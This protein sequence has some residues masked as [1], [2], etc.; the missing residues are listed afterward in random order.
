MLAVSAEDV[1][2]FYADFY[3]FL[4]SAGIDSVKTD[5][6]F[7]LDE[8]DDAPDRAA[9]IRP[10]QNAW[11]LNCLRY[12]SAKAISCMSQAPQIIFH[13]QMPTNKP[14]IMLRNSDDFF[15][16]VPASHPWHV[17][18]N[19]YN[20]LFNQHLN[21]LPDWDMFQTSHPWASFHAAA[22]CVSGGPIYITDVPGAHDVNLIRQM[23]ANTPRGDTVILRPHTIGKTIS[24]YV[25]YDEPVLLKVATYVGRHG[26]GT[27][28]LGVFNTTTRPLTE[29]IPVGDFPGTVPENL[30]LVRAHSSGAIAGPFHPT[31]KLALVQAELPTQ[32]WDILTAYPVKE[33]ELQ[34]R[35]DGIKGDKTIRVSNL[36]LLG[37]MTGAAA[38]VNSDI[39]VDRNSGRLRCWTSLKALGVWGLYVSD[40]ENR[41]LE[42]DFIAVLFG[43]EIPRHC[44]RRSEVPNVLEIDVARAWK[45]SEQR[46]GWSNEVAIEVVIR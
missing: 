5:A 30:Y 16:E 20:T 17:Y 1:Q 15:P 27:P 41:S 9:L 21:V 7:F 25:G 11:I 39:Y 24:P 18:C 23:T 33:L 8:L 28:I 19:A 32:S 12:F 42:D 45:E 13:S 2:Q 38:I 43:R 26:T 4:N 10:Y 31:N 46:A 35:H 3:S 37:K 36:G 22:R 34:R 29:L 40:L 14:R 44:V 6:Q